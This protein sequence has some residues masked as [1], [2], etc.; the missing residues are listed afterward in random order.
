MARVRVSPAL[1]GVGLA[2]V[3]SA[4]LAADAVIPEV[5]LDAAGPNRSLPLYGAFYLR[6]E[7]KPGVME[8]HPIFVRNNYTALG[9]G[10]VVPQLGCDKVAEALRDFKDEPGVGKVLGQRLGVVDI[11]ELWEPPPEGTA[12][13][14]VYRS[15]NR[16]HEAFVP[17]P[18][19]R[20]STSEPTQGDQ[21]K[22]LVSGPAFFRPGATY[23][24][25]MFERHRDTQQDATSVRVALL[26]YGREV[27]EAC[28]G[29][30]SAET[31]DKQQMADAAQK[32]LL[33]RLAELTKGLP[34]PQRANIGDK[35][36]ETQGEMPLLFRSSLRLRNLMGQWREGALYRRWDP[37]FLES[38][39]EDPLASV[40]AWSLVRRGQLHP[41]F[42]KGSSDV[43]FTLDGKMDVR[44]AGLLA[45]GKGVRLAEAREEK[46]P[47]K[48][49]VLDVDTGALRLPDSEL[50]LRDVLEFASGRVR[51][52]NAYLPIATLPQDYL[53]AELAF[54]SATPTTSPGRLKEVHERLQSLQVLTER[55][56]GTMRTI[57]QRPQREPR[58]PEEH[59][60]TGLGV[61]LSTQVLQDCQAL[62]QSKGYVALF[63][64]S[65]DARESCEGEAAGKGPSPA[66]TG[67]WPGFKDG[68][69]E[70]EI[71]ARDR[72]PLRLLNA[73]VVG[74][75]GAVDTWLGTRESVTR[76]VVT[77]TIKSPVVNPPT[78]GA[79]LNQGTWFDHYVTAH[80]GYARLVSAADPFWV[81][82][83]GIQLYL[84]P[85]PVEEP[86]WSNG[87]R[88]WRR[89][90]ALELGAGLTT[91]R[92][93]P[94]NRYS[95]FTSSGTPPLFVGAAFQLLPYTTVSTGVTLLHA[96]QTSLDSERP[97]F[98]A[99][100]YLGGSVQLNVVG[101]IRNL[102]AGKAAATTKGSL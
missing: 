80:T 96:R 54:D 101:I 55:I 48:W 86:M 19:L 38:V 40:L 74:Y 88:D 91:G 37:P 89:L 39:K 49:Q 21:F 63:D 100:H 61:W 57:A 76:T 2:L 34:E 22:V 18:W 77:E 75:T 68:W 70:P 26:A 65:G 36:C 47:E 85:N 82:Q 51:L 13:A 31:C 66:R 59:V 81:Q 84:W 3:A 69:A 15:L 58:T 7:A 20:A 14:S 29:A 71:A 32:K 83:A 98:M 8:V 35:A 44:Y 23:C 92:F 43:T 60:L 30:T 56:W 16:L 45:D 4:A 102:A 1:W 50:S 79:T 17:A 33:A 78:V 90:V 93:G 87:W 46:V 10:N 28:Q 5:T 97:R 72:S 94:L 6:G 42:A 27:S 24:L 67:A 53:R 41:V 12:R 95:G 25:L 64:A 62:L 9:F 52:G 73:L 11:D 99:Q